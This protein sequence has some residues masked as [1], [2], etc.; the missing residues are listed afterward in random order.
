MVVRANGVVAD[1]DDAGGFDAA[2]ARSRRPQRRAIGLRRRQAGKIA[3]IFQ[4]DLGAAAE[5]DEPGLAVLPRDEV[6]AVVVVVLLE[7]EAVAG[8][9]VPAITGAFQH[10][11]LGGRPL[12]RQA[13]TAAVLVENLLQLARLR[14]APRV[15][16]VVVMRIT[17]SVFV[18]LHRLGPTAAKIMRD[19][20]DPHCVGQRRRRLQRL[21]RQRERVVA[22]RVFGRR[23][24]LPL[25]PGGDVEVI[26]P[27]RRS[28][29]EAHPALAGHLR[30]FRRSVRQNQLVPVLRMG[31]L[32]VDP[33]FLH[34]SAG[35]VEVRLVVLH[36][37][38]SRQVVA[39][40]AKAGWNAAEHLFQDLRDG[41]PL[42][43]AAATVLAR[44]RTPAPAPPGTNDTRH[45]GR[46]R[47]VPGL[48]RDRVAR[49]H[50]RAGTPRQSAAPVASRM[51]APS[52][53]APQTPVP[54]G[55]ARI[56]LPTRRPTSRN[57]SEPEG[58]VIDKQR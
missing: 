56:T 8:K 34:Q 26:A 18:N 28:R 17:A 46:P 6:L 4:P 21:R 39:L 55:T 51:P 40:Q 29:I 54:R 52:A 49:S 30:R 3:G 38:V 10:D 31:K 14:R 12:G 32:V 1:A 48:S 53:A 57:P 16:A 50:R 2:Q 24:P 43:H 20:P 47:P 22:Q 15:H 35:E 19:A 27:R 33:F 45:P 36:A 23:Q 7:L 9:E 37:V 13:G 58:V 41:L 44:A 25:G 5:V 42:K 11:G